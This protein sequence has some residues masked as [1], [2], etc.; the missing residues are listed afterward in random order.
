[1]G[2]EVWYCTRE[3]V[4][5]ALDVQHTARS[6]PQVDRAV[7]SGARGIEELL[8]RRFYPHTG[9][10]YFDLPTLNGAPPWRLW[11]DSNTLISVTEVTSGGVEIT[12]YFLRR[13][14]GLEEPPYTHIELDRGTSAAFGGGTSP[15]RDIAITGVWGY[16]DD[17]TQVGALTDTLGTS[18]S[19]GITLSPT[20]GVGSLLRIDSERLIVTAKTMVDSGQN[21]GGT[22]LAA[23]AA[24]VTVP[25]SNGTAFEAGQVLLVDAERM[26]V[27]DI[28]GNNLIVKR[29]WDGTVLA[30][31]TVGADVYTLAGFTVAR[32]QLGT[33]TAAHSSGTAI[34]RFEFPSL[35]QSLNVAEAVEQLL[36]ETSGYGRTVGTGDNEREAAGK[37]LA[38][39][40]AEAVIAYGRKARKAVV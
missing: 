20:V 5:Q 30:A 24:D 35:I 31:H 4:K 34:C 12:D 8:H 10:R 11:L 25:V 38:G 33:T 27:V 2:T 18:G 29:A 14:D 22:G 16:R 15:Q 40:R 28:T 32:G 37:G 1:M 6:D 7:A 23:S 36:Q 21:V 26:L 19:A 3:A 17:E 13:S 9:T 39:I